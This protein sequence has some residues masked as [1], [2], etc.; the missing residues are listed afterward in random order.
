[1]KIGELKPNMADVEIE[2]EV[3]SMEEPRQA[4]TKYGPKPV[5]TAHLKDDTG[6]IDLTLWGNQ[7][8]SVKAGDKVK[9]TGGFVKEWNG[10]IQLT[11]TRNGEIQ[12]L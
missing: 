8:S 11:V 1:M 5:A 9:I 2:A 6:T 7:I 3:E 12:V 4:Q 10:N